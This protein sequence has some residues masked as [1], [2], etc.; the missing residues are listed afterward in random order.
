MVDMRRISKR[1]RVDMRDWGIFTECL[2]LGDYIDGKGLARAVAGAIEETF[3]EMPPYAEF[4]WYGKKAQIAEIVMSL[5]LSRNE[6]GCKFTVSLDALVGD[7]ISLFSNGNG[8]IPKD[9][10][11]DARC[12]VRELI[13]AAKRIADACEDTTS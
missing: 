12:L 13:G 6:T 11:E 2:S 3:D 10:A 1:D 7:F 8:K 5:P 4:R 9:D